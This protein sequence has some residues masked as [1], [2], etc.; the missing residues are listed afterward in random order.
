[1]L[2]LSQTPNTLLFQHLY[3]SPLLPSS[4]K[5][6]CFISSIAFLFFV[7]DFKDFSQRP[8]C[9]LYIIT[10]TTKSTTVPRR[11][12]KPSPIRSPISRLTKSPT[13]KTKQYNF[14][15]FPRS[16]LACPRRPPTNHHPWSIKSK[17]PSSQ[18]QA[19]K[20]FRC[21]SAAAACCASIFVDH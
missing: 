14:L 10:K 16:I 15:Y 5:Y 6:N 9:L 1:M 4:F 18:H 7:Y 21:S 11:H 19:I 17:R 20:S 3:Y 8:F 2:S 12:Y 13:R